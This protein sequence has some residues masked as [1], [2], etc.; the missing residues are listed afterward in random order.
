MKMRA[1]VLLVAGVVMLATMTV[2]L[3]APADGA[4]RAGP[5]WMA[6]LTTEQKSE[7]Q[8][9]VK[10]LRA[11]GKNREEIKA[12]ITE[13]LK[14]WN[15]EP[16]QGQGAGKGQGRGGRGQGWMADLTADQRTQVEAKIKELK[17]AG[18]T[19]EEIRATVTE[20]LKGWGLAAPAGRGGA[21]GGQG[22]QGGQG[23]MADLTAEQ[24][25]EVQAKIKELKAAGKTPAEIRAVVMEMRKGWGI[26]TPQGRQARQG[27]GGLMKGVM[28]KLTPAQRTE[29]TGKVK[30]LRAAGKTREEIRTA[31]ADLLKGWNIETPAAP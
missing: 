14:G 3:A 15:V 17:A 21:Q 1:T 5:Q 28:E 8:E 13:M 31:V 2:C 9:K 25:T 26:E 23:R 27:Q 6:N 4:K 10:T 22:G 16:P 12:A 30:E 11:E 24:R 18:K 7:V 29:L 19:P 20:M